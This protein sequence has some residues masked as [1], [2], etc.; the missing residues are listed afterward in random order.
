MI[1]LEKGKRFMMNIKDITNDY[2]R[3]YFNIDVERKV[4]KE[5]V[6]QDILFLRWFDEM[7]GDE[8]ILSLQRELREF[9][10]E[11]QVEN[12]IVKVDCG[13]YDEH[14]SFIFKAIK[15]RYESDSE[16]I[17]R[18]KSRERNKIR[19]RQEKIKKEEEERREFERL[20]RKF[21]EGN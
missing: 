19:R 7:D 4:K 13:F 17:S 15:E 1:G 12:V 14:D 9:K 6:E 2:I 3:E 20:A 16:V 21:N 8:F 18:L 5:K 10:S 11:Y